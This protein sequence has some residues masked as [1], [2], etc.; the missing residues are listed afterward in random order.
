MILGIG[1]DITEHNIARKFNW[2]KD[3]ALQ[4]SIFSESELSLSHNNRMIEFLCG[5]FAA[6]EAVAKCLKTGFSDRCSA[7]EIEILSSESGVPFIKLSGNTKK[8]ANEIGVGEWQVSISHSRDYS[9][10]FVIALKK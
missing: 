10:S 3:T 1:C 2:D 4:H 9:I 7:H 8:F 5:R 6:K